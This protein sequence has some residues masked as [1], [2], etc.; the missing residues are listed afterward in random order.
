MKI[1]VACAEEIQEAA[2]L[3]R[4]C[5]TKQDDPDFTA[6][7]DTSD[8]QNNH[9]DSAEAHVMEQSGDYLP[10]P[11]GEQSVQESSQSK[12]RVKGGIGAVSVAL[13]IVGG[14][15]A[16]SLLGSGET[17][18]YFEKQLTKEVAFDLIAQPSDFSVS[19]LISAPVNEIDFSDLLANTCPGSLRAGESLSGGELLAIG[20]VRP[21]DMSNGPSIMI[22]Q[23]IFK[24]D[25]EAISQASKVLASA[26]DNP[27]CESEYETE[28]S[29]SSTMF[30]NARSVEQQ[31]GLDLQGTVVDRNMLFASGDSWI[32]VDH[33]IVLAFR[34]EYA[35]A[36]MFGGHDYPSAS[37]IDMRLLKAF[38][39][40]W[41]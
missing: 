6:S 37:G 27:V 36:M 20:G 18:S 16:T 7:T 17:T 15:L 38:A 14:M 12:R 8:V 4:F 35:M 13:A 1:C 24:L 3:C 28:F 32:E 39:S 40:I 25:E 9:E 31:Y 11:T 22:H 2:K 34:G 30:L 26:A 23:R 19:G 29:Y 21:A 33:T 5:G 10:R 41:D